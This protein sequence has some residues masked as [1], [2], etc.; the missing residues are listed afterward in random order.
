MINY[1]LHKP[2]EVQSL[3]KTMHSKFKRNSETCTSTRVNLAGDDD[4]VENTE[5]LQNTLSNFAN[6]PRIKSFKIKIPF[7]RKRPFGK[8]DSFNGT[9]LNFVELDCKSRCHNL[10]EKQSKFFKLACGRA[11]SVG[12]G[13]D[14]SKP[15]RRPS[16]L[17]IV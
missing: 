11:N 2:N 16:G 6:A 13:Q 3:F 8:H 7:F 10:Y 4:M 9:E 5:N 15:S 14:K 12:R 17:R 1:S